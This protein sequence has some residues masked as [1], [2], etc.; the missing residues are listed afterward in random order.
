MGINSPCVCVCVCVCV[1]STST[2]LGM[3]NVVR[4]LKLLSRLGICVL[5]PGRRPMVSLGIYQAGTPAGALQTSR[6]RER[7]AHRVSLLKLGTWNVQSMVDTDGSVEVASQQADGQRGEERKVDQIVCELERYDVVV[8]ALQETKWFGSEVYE[9]GGSVLLTS[10]RVTPASGE[11]VQRGEGVALV[12]RGLALDAW[13][14]GGKQWKA[15][16]SRCVSACLQLAGCGSQKLHVVSCYAPTRA[17]NREDKE[18]FLQVLDNFL[19]SVPLRE[20]FV[21]LGDF[22]SRV[23]SRDGDEGDVW[24]G[25]RGP[26]GLGA[27]NDAGRELLSFLSSHQAI[28]CNTWF[29]KKTIHKQTW[30]HPKSKQWS[31]IDFVVMRQ[32]DRRLCQDV[33]VRRGA[34]CNTDHHLVVAKVKLWRDRQRSCAV[35]EARRARMRRYDVGK[36]LSKG[37]EGQEV[38]VKYQQ[39]V[40]ERADKAWSEDDNVVGKWEAVRAA[41]ISA[42]EDVLGTITRR[43]PDWFQESLGQLRPLLDR[44]NEA[45]ARWLGSGR[46]V[47]LTRFREAR[48]EARRAVRKAKNA[49]FLEKAE[50]VERERFGGK[51]VW[52]C[53]RDM[54]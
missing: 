23:G 19:S 21:I 43:Q 34:V 7:F 44:R 27:V 28:I 17:A 10:G 37:E 49:W 13:K 32:R 18:A 12:L 9:V 16:N 47:D 40:L 51:K 4:W 52:K 53:I 11:A 38:Q 1:C 20:S 29:E 33:T 2:W 48:G 5:S 45:Y 24:T 50:E 3:G 31:S 6:G 14:R 15:W 36:L 46:Q 54:Q 8:G 41:L 22:N 42:A 25:V 30:L 39:E 26:H 35:S